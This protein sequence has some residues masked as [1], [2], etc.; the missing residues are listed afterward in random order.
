MLNKIL[1]ATNNP[2]KQEKLKWILGRY[3]KQIDLPKTSLDIEEEGDS[4][5][6][7]A[8]KKALEA[9]KNYD[10]FTIATDGGMEIP[11]L[12]NS[13]NAL[14]TKR[15]I[16]KE[17]VTDFDRMDALLELMKDK[18]D[19]RMRWEEAVAVAY[20]GRVVFSVTVEGA[21]GVLQTSY[22]KSKYKKGIWLCSLWYF[23]SYKKNFFDLKPDQRNFAEV[24]W[25]RIKRKIQ[26]FFAVS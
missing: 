10:G 7:I 5:E 25:H 3:F 2:H 13:W 23:P 16:G 21:K 20:K 24:S 17:N 12:R 9:S 15:F 14:F 1:L 6:E 4:F 18:K 8:K 22:D 11:V 26:G 19:R